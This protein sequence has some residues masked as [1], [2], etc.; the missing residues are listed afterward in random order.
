MPARLPMSEPATPVAGVRA[1]LD[2]LT[3]GDPSDTLELGNLLDGLGR[4]AFGV[5]LFLAIPPAVFPG[6]AAVIGAPLVILIGLHL[7]L[8]RRHVWLPRWLS[9]RG[10][11]RALIIRFER[12]FDKLFARL[13]R[14][15]RPRW[16][17]MFTHPLAS[18]FTGVLLI[19]LGILL[20]LPIPFTNVPFALL[21]LLFALALLE[22]DGRLMLIAWL[23]G[24]AAITLIA[25]L[26]GGI[27]G[28]IAYWLG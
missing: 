16:G 28:A 26:S 2:Q 1:L 7:L 19:L 18:I 21:L 27:A 14:W 24:L 9:E 22:R 23:L 13:E 25:S 20:A 10:P 8:R 11:H 6:V 12:R 4:R 3:T 15:I 5:L 17:G